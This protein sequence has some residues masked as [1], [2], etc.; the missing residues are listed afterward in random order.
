VLEVP[1]RIVG[2]AEITVSEAKGLMDKIESPNQFQIRTKNY[3]DKFSK[4]DAAK[5]HE[6]LEDLLNLKIERTDAI[7]VIN[8]MPSTLEELRAFFSSGRKRLVVT[9]QLEEILKSLE[10]YR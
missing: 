4:V 10:K 5:A 2:K 8:S 6:L 9:A 1:K 7:Q 3:V